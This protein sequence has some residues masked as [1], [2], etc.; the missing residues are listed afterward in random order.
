M[1]RG[2]S[3]LNI[4]LLI[5]SLTVSGCGTSSNPAIHYTALGASDA[6]GVGALPPTRGYVF[7]I[8][9]GLEQQV[10]RSVDLL[11]LGIP[12]AQVGEI[13]EAFQKSIQSGNRPDLVTLWT[14]SNDL[15]HGADPAEFEAKLRTL[16]QRVR[17]K[18]TAFLVLANL[19][20]LTQLPVFVEHPTPTVTTARI[21]TF[22]TAI[23]RQALAVE[24]TVVHLYEQPIMKN[25]VSDIDGFH[26]SNEGH[27]ELASLFL[28]VILPHFGAAG[29]GS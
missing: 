15:I 3:I 11:N 1:H 12:G 29:V 8:R 25:A 10:G 5:V 26:P 17:A 4:L 19:P 23:E 16:L 13:D 24:A 27:A 7:R 28:H 21:S 9:E 14:G 20:D 22:N 2:V 18:T 6:V